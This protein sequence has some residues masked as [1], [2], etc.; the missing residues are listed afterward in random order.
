MTDQELKDLVASLA[1]DAKKEYDRREE[2]KKVRIEKEEEENKIRMEEENK[3]KEEW[4]AASK[5]WDKLEKQY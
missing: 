2:E 4:D 5:R 1:I 3:R